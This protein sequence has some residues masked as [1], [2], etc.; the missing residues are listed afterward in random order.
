MKNR[1]KTSLS[2]KKDLLLKKF[3]LLA[4]IIVKKLNNILF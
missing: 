2:D 4:K 1:Q 3:L